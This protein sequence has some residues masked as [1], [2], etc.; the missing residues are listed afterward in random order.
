MATVLPAE[1]FDAGAASE[2][3]R[4]SMKGF[5]TDESVIIKLLA[6]HTNEQ[7]Q[8]I[9]SAFKTAYGE[10]L[11]DQ[12]KSEL[13]GNF[14]DAVVAMMTKPNVY[15][16][17][18]LRA[19]MKGA[20]TDEATLVEI[21]CSRTNDDIEAIKQAYEEEFERNLEEDFQNETSGNFKRLLVSQ[22]NAGRDESEDVDDDKARE[23]AQEMYD[24]GEGQFGTDESTINMV[25]C[26]RSFPQL[27]ATFHAYK[28]IADKDLEDAIEAETSGSLQDGFIAIVR[29]ARDMSD[30]FARRLY[31]SM[32]GAGTDDA[33]LIRIVVSRSEIDLAPIKEAF[34]ARYETSLSEFISD[35]CGGDHKRLLLAVVGDE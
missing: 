12:L 29:C 17:Q 34:Q 22:C 19:A 25:L 5:G 18:Q 21:M 35:D 1:D 27:R 9:A 11:V 28:E 24:A 6:R 15:D 13:G 7:R 20:G 16:A 32:K 33:A 23:D 26:S 30:F 10:E 8:E 14:E 2:D 31:N 3:L 4:K